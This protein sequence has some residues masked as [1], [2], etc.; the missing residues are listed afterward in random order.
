MY[1]IKKSMQCN[2]K[3]E[4]IKLHFVFLSPKPSLLPTIFHLQCRYNLMGEQV[5]LKFFF[6]Q[7]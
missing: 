3:A 4:Q 5:T 6:A 7:I 1:S 2:G